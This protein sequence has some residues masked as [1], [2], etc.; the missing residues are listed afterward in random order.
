MSKF[1][2][3][4][5]VRSLMSARFAEYGDCGADVGS[6]SGITFKGPIEG[7]ILEAPL[8][9][10]SSFPLVCIWPSWLGLGEFA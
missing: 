3:V 8:F 7:P 10:A 9:C 2:N 4:G 5:R 6:D 1:G